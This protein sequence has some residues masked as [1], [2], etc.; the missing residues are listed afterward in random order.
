[1]ESTFLLADLAGFTAL[2]EAHGDTEAAAVADG[3]LRAVRQL[4]PA[5][6]GEEVKSIGDAVLVRLPDAGVAVHLAARLVG[7][8]GARHRGL[9]VRVG[10]HTGTAVRRGDDWFGAAVN[11]ASRVADLAGPGE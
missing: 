9:D 3:F 11:L 2:T 10:I 4:L 8:F 7:D 5:Y 1:M 6:D